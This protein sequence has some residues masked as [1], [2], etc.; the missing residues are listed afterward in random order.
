MQENVIL[1]GFNCGFCS[2]ST[3]GLRLDQLYF[4]V[5]T[6]DDAVIDTE[7][8]VETDVN[9]TNSNTATVTQSVVSNANTGNNTA[10]GGIGGSSIT[11]GQALV[12]AGVSANTNSNLTAL[13]FGGSNLASNLTDIVNTGDDAQVETETR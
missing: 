3:Y 13:E 7:A 6:G 2:C 10:N 9:V 8:E 11:T 1:S 12:G 5:N 4:F